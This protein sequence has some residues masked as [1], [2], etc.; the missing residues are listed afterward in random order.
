V[1]EKLYTENIYYTEE[2]SLQSST[3]KLD[4][5]LSPS[6]G[7]SVTGSSTHVETIFDISPRVHKR[8]SGHCL[9]S[10]VSCHVAGFE[11]L[12]FSPNNVFHTVPEDKV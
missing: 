12:Q 11:D 6:F 9:Q 5:F 8:N 3:T 10:A 1:R 2:V 4:V 7:V